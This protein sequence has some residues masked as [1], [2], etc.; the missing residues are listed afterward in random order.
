MSIASGTIVA[1][2]INT[3]KETKSSLNSKKPITKM[4]K[5]DK[6]INFLSKILFLLLVILTLT[7]FTIGGCY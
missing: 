3:G 2:V 5:T 1:L 4:G 6:E 7:I